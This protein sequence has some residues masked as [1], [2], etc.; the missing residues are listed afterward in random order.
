MKNA[1]DMIGMVTLHQARKVLLEAVSAEVLEESRPKVFSALDGI[2]SDCRKK[3]SDLDVV[4][5]CLSGL[6][7]RG[8]SE[9]T[10][11][12][13]MGLSVDWLERRPVDEV[14]SS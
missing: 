11:A 10:M 4:R 13:V 8:A 2:R 3:L 12:L 6:I 1:Y 14:S 7:S 9:T 5:L